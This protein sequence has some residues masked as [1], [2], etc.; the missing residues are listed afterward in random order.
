MSK[1]DFVHELDLLL[2]YTWECHK[3]ASLRESHDEAIRYRNIIDQ[4]KYIQR[5][6]QENI[7]PSVKKTKQKEGSGKLGLLNTA[8]SLRPNDPIDW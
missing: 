8:H 5:K 3:D 7:E 2:N 6:N 4:L 1:E